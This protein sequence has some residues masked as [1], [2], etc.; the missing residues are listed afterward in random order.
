MNIIKK[1]KSYVIVIAMFLLIIFLLA[2]IITF[3]KNINAYDVPI[4]GK[5]IEID[6]SYMGG[7]RYVIV[8]SNNCIVISGDDI[9]S[10]KKYYLIN[11]AINTTV[12]D[13]DI[14]W[15]G[16]DYNSYKQIQNKN[17]DK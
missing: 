7:G 17:K 12:K 13:Y 14:I 9:N 3:I 2:P 10:H 4:K 15:N 1:Y 11:D 6:K 5:I 16:T 8:N